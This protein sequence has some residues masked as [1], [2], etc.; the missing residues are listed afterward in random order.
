[1]GGDYA[2]RRGSVPLHMSPSLS[3]RRSFQH[4]RADLLTDPTQ[5]VSRR[6]NDG[7]AARTEEGIRQRP[8]E[9]T[10]QAEIRVFPPRVGT[11]VRLLTVLS[12]S[13]IM[14]KKR[15]S[16]TRFLWRGGEGVAEGARAEA[17]HHGYTRSCSPTSLIPAQRHNPLTIAGLPRTTASPFSCPEKGGNTGYHPSDN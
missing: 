14:K 17:L 11:H 7:R 15:P 4:H 10:R 3:M 12:C 2:A 1:M 13:V 16:P 5:L 9:S 8:C 6:E